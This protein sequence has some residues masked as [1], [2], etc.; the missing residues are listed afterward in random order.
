MDIDSLGG[1][2]RM[3]AVHSLQRLTFQRGPDSVARGKGSDV[4]VGTSRPLD[5]FREPG[6]ERLQALRALGTEV[7]R[8]G[9]ADPPHK[10]SLRLRITSVVLFLQRRHHCDGVV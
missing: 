2:K 5:A 8:V 10:R 7:A 9:I 6:L 4:I 1:S 3:R